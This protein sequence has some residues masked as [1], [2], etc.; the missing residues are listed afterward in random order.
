MKDTGTKG[1]HCLPASPVCFHKPI[2]II[3]SSDVK[4][5]KLCPCMK[6]FMFGSYCNCSINYGSQGKEPTAFCNLLLLHVAICCVTSSLTKHELAQI[7][8]EGAC[9]CRTDGASGLGN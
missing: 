6:L 5:C 7:I 8:N 9:I 1:M 3:T 2:L 4:A